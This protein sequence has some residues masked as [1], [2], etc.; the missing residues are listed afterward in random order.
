MIGRRAALMLLLAGLAPTAIAA[1]WLW[2]LGWPVMV[3]AT[4]IV[5]LICAWLIP[6]VTASSNT[7]LQLRTVSNLLS[8][9]REGD[10]SFRARH[11]GR[12][13]A[14]S[15]LISQLNL[16]AESLRRQRV[17]DLEASVLL[18]RVMSEIDVAV[19]TFDTS[20][21]LR[22]LNPA[23]EDLLC[24]TEAPIGKHAADLGLAECLQGEAAR[25]IELSL[26]ATHTSWEMRR[27]AYRHHGRP[28]TLLVLSDVTTALRQEE[29]S[30]WKRLIRILGHELNSSLAPISSLTGSMSRLL[31]QDPPPPDLNDDLRRGLEIIASRTEALN[32]FMA[33][34]SA[35]ARLPEPTCARFDL[36]Q[37]IRRAVALETRQSIRLRGGPSL[38]IYADEDQLEQ[39]LINL[40]RNAAE[41]CAQ[42]NGSIEISWSANQSRVE[43]MIRDN[44]CGLIEATDV[45]VPFFSTKPGGS[46]IGLFLCRQIVEAHH[47]SVSLRDRADGAGCEALL[48]LPL[49]QS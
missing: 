21:R 2:Q 6:V 42:E 25:T 32:R 49:R 43:L 48:R 17:D 13:P 46:G 24:T 11:A 3:R 19:L 33:Q 15:E 18:R 29:L 26:G 10:Y 34:C 8:A 47:G 7:R 38:M 41:A 12:D 27:G 14:Y 5:L 31:F 22:Q 1:F 4:A 35:L 16:L 40:I 30:A 45:F 39:V 9:L 20:N 36:E 23:G 37:C 28:R 44:G